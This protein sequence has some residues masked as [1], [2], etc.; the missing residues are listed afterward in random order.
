MRIERKLQVLINTKHVADLH[1]NNGLWRL[2]YTPS[3][4]EQANSYALAPSL[5]LQAESIVDSG[6]E[7]PVQWFF[8][9]LL[10]EEMARTLLANEARVSVDDAFTLL[11]LVGGE[12]AGAITL[13]HEGE[14]LA[15]PSV[16]ALSERELSQ[17]IRDLPRAP[18]NKG[19]RKRMSL[20]GA[21]LWAQ[22]SACRAST[23]CT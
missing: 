6:S 15:A 4:C 9:N 18:M 21:Q 5:P 11:E 17:R 16:A 2:Q 20:A 19:E 7:R 22:R 8:D 3:W 10:P 14:T 23:L 13:L 1:E 12:S